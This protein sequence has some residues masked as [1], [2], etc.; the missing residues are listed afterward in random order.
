M[1]C[2]LLLFV[3]VTKLTRCARRSAFA[4]YGLHKVSP[5]AAYSHPL[6]LYMPY[7]KCKHLVGIYNKSLQLLAGFWLNFVGVTRFELR[8]SRGRYIKK[9]AASAALITLSPATIL[10][11]YNH[12]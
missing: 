4:L 1:F 6:L 10:P 5:K 12:P 9:L 3:G 2:Y 11:K 8:R 7:H